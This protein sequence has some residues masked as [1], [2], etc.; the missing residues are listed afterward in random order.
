[1]SSI[2]AT[3][4]NWYP[5]DFFQPPAFLCLKMLVDYLG[6]NFPGSDLEH[7]AQLLLSEMEHL[8]PTPGDAEAPVPTSTPLP[9]A[10]LGQAEGTAFP[11]ASASHRR[12]TPAPAMA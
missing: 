9:S 2:L 11:G 5:E 3:W 6:F 8:E 1:M 7:Q 12:L 10:E 4:L